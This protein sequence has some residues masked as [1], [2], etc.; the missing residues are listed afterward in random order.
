[1]VPIYIE[2]FADYSPRLS[3]PPN[4]KPGIITRFW[5]GPFSAETL[6]VLDGNRLIREIVI[7]REYD[8]LEGIHNWYIDGVEVDEAEYN[9]VFESVFG[10]WYET[11]R[12]YIHE[13]TEANIQDIIS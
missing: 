8:F 12:I 9:S 11:G 6:M 2:R 13:I 5:E 1:M 3:A 7:S 4:N 10:R